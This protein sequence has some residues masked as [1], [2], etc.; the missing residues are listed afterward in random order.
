MGQNP[1]WPIYNYWKNQGDKYIFNMWLIPS[2]T[3]ANKSMYASIR[4]TW[5]TQCR[6]I[7]PVPVQCWATVTA[8]CWC[9]A[10]QSNSTLAQYWN[11][12]GWLSCVSSDSLTYGWRIMPK[13]TTGITRYIG[14]IVKQ[15]WATVCDA[16]PTLFQPK[17]FKLITTNII[18]NIFF[19]SR[20]I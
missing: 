9:N 15:C 1:E 2:T 10:G 5:Y 11:R 8:H 18:L 6:P 3:I 7:H 13:A 17:P 16:G 19:F 4:C 20:F 12:T 14:P